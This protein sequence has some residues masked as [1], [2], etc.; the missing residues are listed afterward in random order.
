M[1]LPSPAPSINSLDDARRAFELL[2]RRV[3]QLG[4]AGWTALTYEGT[5]D[6]YGSGYA[7]G[8]YM[9]DGLGFVHLKGVLAPDTGDIANLPAGY[10]PSEHHVFACIGDGT[11]ACQVEV[12]TDGDIALVGGAPTSS[13]SLDAIAFRTT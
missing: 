11:V 13:L 5:W 1:S 6:D 8:A 9:I 2:W 7:E 10:R 4:G 12:A 3:S